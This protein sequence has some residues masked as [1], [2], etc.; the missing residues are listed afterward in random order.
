M[1]IKHLQTKI[2]VG[3]IGLVILLGL[4]MAIFIKTVVYEKLSA[5]LEKRGVFIAKSVANDSVDPLLTEK[6]Y[7]LEMMVRT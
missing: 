7:E 1:R 5:N 3:T 2:L 4:V 6:F